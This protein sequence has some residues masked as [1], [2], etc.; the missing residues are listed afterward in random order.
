MARFTPALL[1]ALIAL[2]PGVFAADLTPSQVMYNTNQLSG[3]KVQVVGVVSS[4]KAQ[5][6][7]DGKPYQSFKLCDANAC[8]SVMT[9]EKTVYKEGAEITVSG[10][11]WAVLHQG[12]RTFYNELNVD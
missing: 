10:H 11:F 8:L 5:T 9:W 12:Y 7:P 4:L 1:L 2:S 3:Q 6:S